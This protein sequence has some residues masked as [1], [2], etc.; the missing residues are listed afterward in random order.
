MADKVAQGVAVLLDDL[1]GQHDHVV[2]APIAVHVVEGLEVVQVAIANGEVGRVFQQGCN[3]AADRN[4]ARQGRQRVGV[5]R[6]LDPHFSHGTH[7]RFA[8]CQA[9]VAA[10]PRDDQA[11]HQVALVFR[12]QHVAELIDGDVQIHQ[13]RLGVHE[14]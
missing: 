3:V 10:V 11:V 9:V 13:H 2:A 12:N 14:G 4:V 5:A 6:G 7:Q 1:G 8:G